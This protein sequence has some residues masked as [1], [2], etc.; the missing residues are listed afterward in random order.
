MPLPS[1]MKKW[2]DNVRAGSISPLHSCDLVPIAHS[3]SLSLDY[4]GILV[5][6]MFPECVAL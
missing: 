6:D 3:S 1:L 2:M 5:L 4:D